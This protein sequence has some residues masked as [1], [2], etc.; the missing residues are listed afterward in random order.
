MRTK[1]R[2][3][4]DQGSAAVEFALVLPVLLLI[5]FAI[6]DFGRMLNARIILSQAAHEGAR[7]VEVTDDPD[8]AQARVAMTLDN[9]AGGI[10]A[11]SI[12]TCDESPDASVTLTYQFS[13]VTP[14]AIF[15]GFGDE[16]GTTMTAT[17][18]VPCL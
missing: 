18:V 7:A 12:V 2:S 17:A 11:Q 8:Q 1:R 16:S 13:Y 15:A 3:R 6:I 14:L 4:E 10:T 5:I 9:L